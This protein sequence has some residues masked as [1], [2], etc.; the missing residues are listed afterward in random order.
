VSFT[1]GTPQSALP[2]PKDKSDALRKYALEVVETWQITHAA[3]H[4]EIRVAYRYLKEIL[5]VQFPDTRVSFSIL[6]FLDD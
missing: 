1:I 4:Q 3:H 5:R 6:S 2:P